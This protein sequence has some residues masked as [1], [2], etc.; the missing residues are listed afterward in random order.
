VGASGAL[1]LTADGL[2]VA[3]GV[4]AGTAS[5]YAELASATGVAL[6]V[7]AAGVGVPVFATTDRTLA[8]GAVY[9]VFV[10]GGPTPATG[11]LRQDR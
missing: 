10:L 5:A 1:S 7:T 2:P 3:G 11:L 9:T 8:A 6:N 4:A